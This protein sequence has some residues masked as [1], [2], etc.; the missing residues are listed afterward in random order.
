MTL[1]TPPQRWEAAARLGWLAEEMLTAWRVARD[2]KID[3]WISARLGFVPPMAAYCGVARIVENIEHGL[4]EPLPHDE[5]GG[6]AAL[7]IP[8][9][10]AGDVIDIVAVDFLT[11]APGLVPHWSLRAGLADTLGLNAADPLAAAALDGRPVPLSIDPVAW[12]RR[13]SA[14]GGDTPPTACLLRV[15]EDAP[16]AWS[17]VT[18]GSVVC[19]GD[20]LAGRIHEFRKRIDKE[21][22][23]GRGKILVEGGAGS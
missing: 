3:A 11:L 6:S 18:R 4:Y 9:L 14:A 2:P 5:E 17:L 15:G 16:L 10:Q 12:L 21:A 8:V 19:D 1:P 7:L 13:W 20:E 23:A 22:K